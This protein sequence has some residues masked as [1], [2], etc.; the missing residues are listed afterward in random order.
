MR[1]VSGRWKGK[2]LVAPAGEATRPTSDRARQAVFNI[3]EHAPWSPGL[4]D[5]RVLDLFAGTGAL[6]LEA[7]SRGATSCLFLDT[8]PAA[9]AALMTN[10]E[11]CA[12]QGVTRVWKRDASCLD[13]MPATAS[14]PFDLIFV[15]P[16]YGKGLD[17]AALTGLAKN[18]LAPEALIVLERGRDE[19]NLRADG[20]EILDT[21][22]YGAAQIVFLQ[23]ATG[24]GGAAGG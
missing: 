14:G 1:I 3:I 18:W 9:R 16:P 10:I 22:P 4:R 6:G 12:A 15:D 2:A 5:A 24:S 17:I 20:Y 21:R 8:D 11:A 23:L 7:V 13:P 19:G